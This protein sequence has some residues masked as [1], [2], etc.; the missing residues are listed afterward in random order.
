MTSIMFGEK[1]LTDV[2]Y[3]SQCIAECKTEINSR[4][5][6][7]KA[8]ALQ[9]LTFLQMMGY[10]MSPWAS[11]ASIEVMSS[12]RFAHK[13][14]GY[15]AASQGFTQDTEVI[16]LT[17]NLL[18]KELRGASSPS[19]S[20]M[21]GGGPMQSVYEAGLAINCIANIVNEDLARDLL[22]ELTTL[23]QHSQPYFMSIQGLL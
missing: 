2:L 5:M 4:D 17:T 15:L 14:I 3:I 22:P 8:N 7:V 13:R 1:T 19:P 12:P 9:K 23:S 21:S 20:S 10:S 11:F 16:L 18:K 6:I